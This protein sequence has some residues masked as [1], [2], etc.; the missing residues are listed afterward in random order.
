MYLYKRLKLSP[1]FGLVAALARELGSPRV[2]HAF[3]PAH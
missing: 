1:A 3:D 2:D